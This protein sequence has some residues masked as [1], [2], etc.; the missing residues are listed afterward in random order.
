MRI[1]LA[2]LA[3][4]LPA[5]GLAGVPDC[6]IAL[7]GNDPQRYLCFGGEVRLRYERRGNDDFGTGD[8][9]SDA[10]YLLQRVALQ[11]DLHASAHWR[12]F[13]QALSA[14]QYGD[15]A[16]ASPINQ[17]PID[18]QQA[19]VDYGFG[20]VAA[21][22]G[23]LTARLGR[24]GL[25]LGSGRLVATRAAPNVPYK[26]DGLQLIASRGREQLQGFLL[27]PSQESQRQLDGQNDGRSLWGL[28]ATAPTGWPLPATL[29]LYYLGARDDQRRYVRGE[30]DEQRHSIGARLSGD[31]DPWRYDW[32]AVV[33][34]GRFG[35][36]EIRAW[37]LAS[38]TGYRFRGH[39]WQPQISLKADYASG[40]ARGTGRRLGSFNPLY[41]RAAYFN[42]AALIRPTNIIDLHP[43]LQLKPTPALTATVAVEL[44]WRATTRDGIYGPAG[45][46]LLRPATGSS[47]WI[48][49]SSEASLS[50]RAG[51]RWVWTLSYVHLFASDAVRTAGGRDVDFLGGWATFNW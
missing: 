51:R 46:V 30:A 13:A 32:E 48:G 8:G 39:P 9:D 40:D 4:A 12:L 35:D 27:R 3:V 24:F 45:D 42:D 7:D 36:Q 18:L 19:F 1:P 17:N 14:I 34:V 41:F 43:S 28:Y 25:N 29:D 26:F 22:R 23:R 5:C 31:R 37:T 15:R 49:T 2:V 20:D 44:L 16:T 33:Q 21:S 6:S 50:G 10:A 47:R 38:D 11:A